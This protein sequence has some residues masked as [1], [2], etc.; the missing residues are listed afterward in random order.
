MKGTRGDLLR[1][2]QQKIQLIEGE[3]KING[4][5]WGLAGVSQRNNK[6]VIRKFNELLA[7][8]TVQELELF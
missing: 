2:I 8:E 3:V 6:K 5:M 1:N 4:T 7:S